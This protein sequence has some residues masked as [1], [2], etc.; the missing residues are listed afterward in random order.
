MPDCGLLRLQ[1][2]HSRYGYALPHVATVTRITVVPFATTAVTHRFARL[3]FPLPVACACGSGSA[4]HF[5]TAARCRARSLPW[6][7]RWF[8]VAG[9]ARL[10]HM[11]HRAFTAHHAARTFWLPQFH[12]HR[13]T[14]Y[15]RF[16]TCG[17]HYA[18]T[19]SYTLYV[20]FG[21]LPFPVYTTRLVM[22]SHVLRF[23]V[24]YYRLPARL[25]LLYTAYGSPTHWFCLFCLGSAFYRLRTRTHTHCLPTRL[26][27]SAVTPARY[28]GLHRTRFGCGTHTVTLPR[29]TR[30][31]LPGLVRTR[32]ALHVCAA[33]FR[34]VP[35]TAH[36][37]WFGW[38]AVTRNFGL[39][40]TARF[41]PVCYYPFYRVCGYARIRAWFAVSYRAWFCIIFA[42]PPS[43]IR[44]WTTVLRHGL[45]RAP[46]TMLPLPH[47]FLR[48]LPRVLRGCRFALPV[49]TPA[50]P[51]FAHTAH[52]GFTLPA[53]A[54]WV[55]FVA[56]AA[57]LPATTVLRLPVLYGL[58]QVYAAAHR[59]PRFM[60]VLVYRTVPRC[61]QL[62]RLVCG[63][64]LATVP[65]TFTVPF[66]A[67][68]YTCRA[69]AGSIWF[70]ILLFYGYA[71]C[72]CC[73]YVLLLL[74]S[75]VVVVVLFLRSYHSSLLAV[76]AAAD[77]CRT[78]YARLR[79]TF[80]LYRAVTVY[81]LVCW[82]THAHL[83]LDSGS[84]LYLRHAFAAITRFVTSSGST[85]LRLVQTTRTFGLQVHTR[86]FLA[87]SGSGFCGLLRF[88]AV[89]VTV[90][91]RFTRAHLAL[92]LPRLPHVAFTCGLF[93]AAFCHTFY[94]HS[95]CLPR[96]R[97]PRIVAVWFATRFW[98]RTHA[99]RALPHGFRTAL[100][101]LTHHA[102]TTD[103]HVLPV[104]TTAFCTVRF[105][106]GWILLP[107]AYLPGSTTFTHTFTFA[108]RT[109]LP[110]P[111]I[112]AVYH[113]QLFGWFCITADTAVGLPH[114][115]TWLRLDWFCHA[116]FHTR[117]FTGLLLFPVCSSAAHYATLIRVTVATV[118]L[119]LWI[120]IRLLVAF[121][122]LLL[123]VLVLPTLRAVLRARLRAPRFSSADA[124][125][126]TL[127]FTR[128]RAP[129]C[130]LTATAPH[131][132]RFL[133]SAFCRLVLHAF[134]HVTLRTRRGLLVYTPY[135]IWFCTA[136][137]WFWVLR[138]LHAFTL[139]C[140]HA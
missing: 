47:Q 23:C 58:V 54:G 114:L 109:G 121:T 103:A 28:H 105:F 75:V 5:A 60:P 94:A 12:V 19:P 39:P 4:F 118:R 69:T 1:F 18:R 138:T 6:L 67:V 102:F 100:L 98:L 32:Y 43:R 110:L 35:Y 134:L 72:S 2:T 71:G 108:L 104:H 30:F 3:P 128:C 56:R 140:G 85:V 50:A 116:R 113:T 78:C 34:A 9:Y 38:F 131:S 33:W 126:V 80:T 88:T 79:L 136:P 49:A 125:Y 25:R 22:D 41:F 117:S 112:V 139:V 122:A 40:H 36:T 51:R 55:R 84:G 27:G 83:P 11:V 66:H 63:L 120:T 64:V 26:P 97:L 127:R 37:F 107:H 77:G 115:H 124:A 70:W 92:R 89:T 46:R 135:R 73:C 61:V 53:P 57:L 96:L 90:H 14:Y 48:F 123:P 15:T 45:I 132:S 130:L 24:I 13:F 99:A 31:T 21:W 101:R 29:C 95:H 82:F 62:L 17:C 81:I 52:T 137:A 16:T 91:A 68:L 111:R 59:A 119:R 86:R 20:R 76:T 133:G 106:P 93:T 65:R 42:V 7:C 74:H 8:W 87:G 129:H 10:V 44:F